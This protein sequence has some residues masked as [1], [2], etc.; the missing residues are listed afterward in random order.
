MN[1]KFLQKVTSVVAGAMLLMANTQPFVYAQSQSSKTYLPIAQSPQQQQSNTSTTVEVSSAQNTPKT[2]QVMDNMPA[3]ITAIALAEKSIEVTITWSKTDG[4]PQS[5]KLMLQ[6]HQGKEVSTTEVELMVDKESVYRLPFPIDQATLLLNTYKLTIV[7]DSV[8]S[9]ANFDISIECD[10]EPKFMCGYVVNRDASLTNAI[11]LSPELVTALAE[12]K[13]AEN[14][15]VNLVDTIIKD[16]PE[17][18][19][20]TLTY[21]ARL[22]GIINGAGSNPPTTPPDAKECNCYWAQEGYKLP[23]YPNDLYSHPTR[24]TWTYGTEGPGAVSW[25]KTY[26][27]GTRWT[28]HRTVEGEAEGTTLRKFFLDC[29]KV[30]EWETILYP[31]DINRDGIVDFYAEIQVPKTWGPCEG[32]CRGNVDVLG[33]AFATAYAKP[34]GYGNI[35]LAEA[36]ANSQITSSLNGMQFLNNLTPSAYAQGRSSSFNYD[37]DLQLLSAQTPVE[38]RFESNVY[39]KSK[40]R[41]R[42]KVEAVATASYAYAMYG[43]AA[44]AKNNPAYTFEAASYAA[45]LPDFCANINDFYNVRGLGLNLCQ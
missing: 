7:T 31:V 38:V 5:A 15:G 37:E 25:L 4:L 18:H 43:W 26:H 1:R 14:T 32:N 8:L 29:F 28:G 27:D 6:D 12:A 16:H 9:S 45:K 11:T 2:D 17:L 35:N 41:A 10:D 30:I 33:Q 44:C 39:A 42:D 40:G 19:G 3:T 24:E 34:Y 20:E 23:Y 36:W 21:A 13:R 22:S